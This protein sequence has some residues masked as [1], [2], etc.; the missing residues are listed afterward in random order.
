MKGT[1]PPDPF[2]RSGAQDL[3]AFSV[4][5]AFF[6]MLQVLLRRWEILAGYLLLIAANSLA[7]FLA[8]RPDRCGR[9]GR[10]FCGIYFSPVRGTAGRRPAAS[11]MRPTM[12]FALLGLLLFS[13]TNH[14]VVHPRPPLIDERLLSR[15]RYMDYLREHHFFRDP[16][17]AA[18]PPENP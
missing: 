15:T 11:L 5:Y 12:M 4:L 6:G 8:G 10:L 14:A 13:L 2:A 3:H 17:P 16:P 7:A 9:F 18:T 1:S